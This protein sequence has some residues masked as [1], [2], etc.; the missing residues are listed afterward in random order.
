MYNMKKLLL[1]LLCCMC[2]NVI[3]VNA[4]NA[5]GIEP[6]AM[7]IECPRCGGFATERVISTSYK[8]VDETCIHGKGG[9]DTVMLTTNYYAISHDCGYYEKSGS[10]TTRSVISCEGY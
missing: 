4:Q 5:G 3:S 7:G 8:E 10:R 9:T 2:F 6:F 1:A